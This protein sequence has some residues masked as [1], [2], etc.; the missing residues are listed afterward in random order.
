MN[1]SGKICKENIL[2][3]S[4]LHVQLALHSITVKVSYLS[5]GLCAVCGPPKEPEDPDPDPEP[6]PTPTRDHTDNKRRDA[7]RKKIMRPR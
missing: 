5:T 2:P 6:P 3:M 1:L 7:S 4:L